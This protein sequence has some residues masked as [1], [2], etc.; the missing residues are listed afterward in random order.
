V[1][2]HDGYELTDQDYKELYLLH[3]RFGVE[4]PPK[5]A[6]RRSRQETAETAYCGGLMASVASWRK[7]DARLPAG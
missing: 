6:E 4:L 5:N 7:D 3:E 1:L 2:V